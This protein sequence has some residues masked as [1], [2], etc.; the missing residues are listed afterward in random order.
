MVPRI[1]PKLTKRV[2]FLGAAIY[3]IPRLT[4]FFVVCGMIDVLRNKKRN[5]KL[6]WR[7][8]S[9]NGVTTWLLS[10]FNLTMD[11]LALPYKNKGIYALSD[12]PDGYQQEIAHVLRVADQSDFLK[13]LN[14]AMEGRERLMQFFKWY[15]ENNKN[16][17]D[18]SEF[19]QS[20][21]FIRTIGISAFNKYQSTSEHFGPLRVTLRVLYNFGPTAEGNAF[22]EVG[23]Y[24]N[25]WS[26]NPLFIFDDT[27]LHRSCNES[28]GIRYCLFL[29]ILR[30]SPWPQV[31]STI[32]TGVRLCVGPVKSLFYRK[33]KVLR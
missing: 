6:F 32:L 26:D 22:I 30:P 15:G 9:G 3:F 21:K 10:P 8:F 28:D 7:Y 20:Y 16:A 11:G 24:I 13:T 33:W 31:M 29:D 19:H 12:L 14:T 27:L 25:R 18:E 1:I 23:S 17:D 4:L 5:I 2:V